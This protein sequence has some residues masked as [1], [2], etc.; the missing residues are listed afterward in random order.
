[1][2]LPR[3]F[4]TPALSW[5]ARFSIQNQQDVAIKY[6]QVVEQF[7]VP[8]M[9]D[10]RLL[11]EGPGKVETFSG[12]VAAANVGLVDADGIHLLDSINFEFP[13]GADVAIAGTA[14]AAEISCPNSSP[15]SSFRQAG[16]SPSG[17]PTS[18]PCRLRYRAVASAMSGRRVTFSRQACG[19]ISSLV[20]VITRG[21]TSDYDAAMAV[22]R[23]R[24]IEEARQSGNSD[25]DI[26][27]DWVDYQ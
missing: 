26:A 27:A 23:E 6:E 17:T 24:A 8:D 25:L 11:L 12:Q 18:T 5:P 15:G 21:Q 9:L 1:M 20:C 14:T 13:I 16:G 3:S 19:T 10:R 22:R 4:A 7:N 2:R